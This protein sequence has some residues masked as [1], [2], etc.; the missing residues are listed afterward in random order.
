MNCT[1]VRPLLSTYYDGEATPEERAQVERHLARCE[2]CRRA[3]AEY[4]AIGSDLRA[5]PVPIPPAGLRRDVWRAIEA[6][7]TGARSVSTAPIR[8]KLVALPQAKSKP[9]L[10]TV[11]TNLGNGWAKALPA[12]LLV[13]GLAIVVAVLMIKGSHVAVA[14][15]LE[16]QSPFADYGQALHVKFS[17]RV[18]ADQAISNTTVWRITNNTSQPVD[19]TKEPATPGVTDALT[20]RPKAEWQAGGDYQVR[21]DAQNIRT[22]VANETLDD[23]ATVLSFSTFAHTPTPTNTPTETPTPTNTPAPTRTP[24]PTAVAQG[25]VVISTPAGPLPA[26]ETPTTQP[27]RPTRTPNPNTTVTPVAPISTATPASSN[28]PAPT[29]TAAPEPTY[30]PEPTA[31]AQTPTPDPTNTPAPRKGTPTA[32]PRITPRPTGT[33]TPT[34]T[35][36]CSIAPVSG[37]GKIWRANAGVRG[38]IGCPTMSETAIQLAAQQHFQGGYMFWRGDT[39]EIYVFIGTDDDPT[40]NWYLFEDTWRDNDPTQEPIDTPPAGFYEP[41]R[42][43]GKVWR[44]NGYIRQALGWATEPERNITAAWQI[45]EHGYALWTSD[46]IIHFLYNDATWQ[47]FVDIYIAPNSKP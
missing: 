38:R 15:Q 6:Q 43:F 47:R 9:A 44:D 23:H 29:D 30:T 12:A 10:A 33:Q 31:T 35:P 1:E 16:E 45:Y 32:T 21:V 22:G 28:T 46:R 24:Q 27:E 8:G 17:K 18:L 39:H 20:I 14:A 36:A 4:R 37:F 3:L 42:G 5:L 40:G 7:Q 26:V 34:P 25:T 2:D 13:A 11:F 41:I 19:V